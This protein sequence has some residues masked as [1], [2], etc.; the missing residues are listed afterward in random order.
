MLRS[1]VI[2]LRVDIDE[3]HVQGSLF[4]RRVM[5]MSCGHLYIHTY[6]HSQPHGLEPTASPGPRAVPPEQ[7]AQG[8]VSPTLWAVP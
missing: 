1:R 7:S 5:P 8:T 6:I 4:P 3:V 2:A